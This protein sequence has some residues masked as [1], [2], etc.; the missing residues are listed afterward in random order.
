MRELM[1][2]KTYPG[3]HSGVPITGLTLIKTDL[4]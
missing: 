4:E 2:S 3:G 1:L